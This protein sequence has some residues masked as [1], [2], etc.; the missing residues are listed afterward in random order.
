VAG[1]TL[2]L[3]NGIRVSLGVGDLSDGDFFTVQAL[4]DTDTSGVLAAVGINAFFSG[5]LAE[6]MAV[7]SGFDDS[8]GRVATALGSDCADNTNAARLSGLKEEVLD[9]LNG[10]TIGNYYDTLVTTVGQDIT[11]TKLRQDNIEAMLQD[12]LDRRSETSGVDIN[13]ES[14]KILIFEQMYQAM[15][16][17]MNSVQTTTETLMD[18]L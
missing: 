10:R 1:Q 3:G 18:L 16:R 4:A 5:T 11:L 12:L 15:A 13:D 8:P 14:A 17:F 7:L 9:D 2:D 6:S